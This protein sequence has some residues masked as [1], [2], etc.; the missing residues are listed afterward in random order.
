[1]CTTYVE[2]KT[3]IT[4]VLMVMSSMNPHMIRE[5]WDGFWLSLGWVVSKWVLLGYG[6]VTVRLYN[7]IKVFSLRR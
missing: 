6:S 1:M 7:A 5:T 4:V 2:C 3:V